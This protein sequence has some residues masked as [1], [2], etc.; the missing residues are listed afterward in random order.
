LN[1]PQSSQDRYYDALTQQMGQPQAPAQASYYDPNTPDY[2]GVGEGY[3]DYWGGY[4]GGGGFDDYWGTGY[5]PNKPWW[6]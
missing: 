4:G 1:R 3:G 2:F 5:D 6:T